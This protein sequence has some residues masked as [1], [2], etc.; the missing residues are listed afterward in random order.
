MAYIVGTNTRFVIEET[1]EHSTFYC[2]TKEE[3]KA[4][5]FPTEEKARSVL[6]ASGFNG[7]PGVRILRVENKPDVGWGLHVNW[8]QEGDY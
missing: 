3:S 6:A 8:A 4:T 5:I 1:R 2:W 7:V